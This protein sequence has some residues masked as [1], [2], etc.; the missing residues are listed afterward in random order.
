[1]SWN[2]AGPIRDFVLGI[3]DG[4][5]ATPKEAT[6]GPIFLGIKNVTPDG[7]LDFSHI[8]HV[9]EEDFPKWTKR[10]TP[11]KDDIVFSYSH[12][13]SIRNHS[14]GV[15]WMLGAQIGVSPPRQD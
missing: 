2:V 4:P 14:R 12:S 8:R 5:H 3:Y 6:E 1:M 9:S 15:Y 11:Q 7:R 10:V 13:A